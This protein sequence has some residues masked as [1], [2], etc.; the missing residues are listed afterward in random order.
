MSIEEL[1]NHIPD[2]LEYVVPGFL[3]YIFYEYLRDSGREVDEHYK[4]AWILLLS[5]CL[6]S[7]A[8]II[9]KTN[10]FPV[11]FN[12]WLNTQDAIIQ[13]SIRC[14]GESFIGILTAS[15]IAVLNNAIYKNE[16]IGKTFSLFSRT[17]MEDTV[18]EAAGLTSDAIG[19]SLTVYCKSYIISGEFA[20]CGDQT[21]DQWLVL[22]N[23]E[24]CECL[25]EQAGRSICISDK[26][27]LIPYSEINHFT[28]NPKK[29]DGETKG[30]CQKNDETEGKCIP[31]VNSDSTKKVRHRK[32]R[33]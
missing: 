15:A 33:K 10:L 23:I 11:T 18:F 32:R 17:R 9:L 2:L 30:K 14:V 28:V 29:K 13:A 8:T 25:S 19:T 27:L 12:V 3:C 22:K 1:I 4:T 5:F 20:L 6:K 24:K 21:E 16:K 26:Y 31:P 7:I